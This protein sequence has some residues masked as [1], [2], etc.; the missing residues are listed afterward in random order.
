MTIKR[1]EDRIVALQAYLYRRERNWTYKL[2]AEEFNTTPSRAK[3]LT[4]KGEKIYFWRADQYILALDKER[5]A[6]LREYV[7]ESGS[8]RVPKKIRFEIVWQYIYELKKELETAKEFFEFLA[9]EVKKAEAAVEELQKE[10]YAI[11]VKMMTEKQ[12]LTKFKTIY[13]KRDYDREF[14]KGTN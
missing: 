4:L 6:E 7:K 1:I 8:A 5:S 2:I 3:D 10:K 14:P 12:K 11:Q 13:T 9:V